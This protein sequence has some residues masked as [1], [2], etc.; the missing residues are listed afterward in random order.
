MAAAQILWLA[1]KVV[2]G[3]RVLFGSKI[4]Q[5]LEDQS[6]GQ[7]ISELEG[8]TFAEKQVASVKITGEGNKQQHEVGLDA[9]LRLCSNFNCKAVEYH[10]AVENPARPGPGRNAVEILMSSQKRIVLPGKVSGDKL[11]ADQQLYNDLIDLLAS[12]SVGWAPDSV[13]TVGVR[14]VKG[15]SSA[16]WYLDPHHDRFKDRSIPITGSFAEFG[17]TMTGRRKR[18]RGL[19]LPILNLIGM[20]NVSPLFYLSRGAISPILRPFNLK[21][22]HWLR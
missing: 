21:S 16:L 22:W 3:S 10:L 18:K 14:C 13:N 19:K 7:L 11:R 9:P 4:V 12:W 2:S 17:D 15:I 5:C 1:V 8:E 6:F 20:S